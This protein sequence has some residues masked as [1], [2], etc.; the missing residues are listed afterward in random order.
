M[1][2]N[3][4]IVIAGLG[5]LAFLAACDRENEPRVTPTPSSHRSDATLGGTE[6]DNTATN[7]VD[8]MED[9][10]TP[11]DQSESSDD[12]KITAE[13]RR[14]IMDDDSM[15][16]NAQNCKII[17]D[18]SGV[19]TLRGVVNSQAEK[20]SIDAKAKATAGVTRVDNQLEI[21]TN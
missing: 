7:R 11:M 10:K 21:K 6:P 12:I 18:E 1:S 19:V 13:I 20:N 2:T 4:Y 14:A 8:R 17:T 16:M 9:T 15:S 5:A 3:R